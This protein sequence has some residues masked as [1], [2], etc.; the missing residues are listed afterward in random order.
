MNAHLGYSS[1]EDCEEYCDTFDWCFAAEF[2][3]SSTECITLD[4]TD[5][6]GV[7]DVLYEFLKGNWVYHEKQCSR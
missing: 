1:I 4:S 2:R 3:P 7:T 6:A 5:M